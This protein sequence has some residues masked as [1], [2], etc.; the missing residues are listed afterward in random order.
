MTRLLPTDVE[1]R[2]YLLLLAIVTAV[3][4]GFMAAYLGKARELDRIDD[5]RRGLGGRHVRR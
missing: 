1:A 2:V 3:A 4:L 5:E